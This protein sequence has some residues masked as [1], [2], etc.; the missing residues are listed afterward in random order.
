MAVINDI[1]ISINL[2]L[3]NPFYSFGVLLAENA[4]PYF[5][6]DHLVGQIGNDSCTVITRKIDNDA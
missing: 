2:K 4:E 1:I 3:L 5:H 6:C